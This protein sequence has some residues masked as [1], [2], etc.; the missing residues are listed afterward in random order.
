MS[1]I[2]RLYKEG[3]STYTGWNETP[4]FP[5][6]SAN[7]DTIDDPDGAS[8]RNEITSIPSPFA[9]IDLVKTAF[10]EVC[11]L[12]RKTKK[13][14][15]DGKTIFHKMI[16][17]ALDVG[18]IFF[19]ID[20]YQNKIEIISWDPSIMINALQCDGSDGH[21]YLADALQKYMKSDSKTYNFD[22]LQ[23]IYLLNY[24]DGPDELNIIGATSPATLFFSSANKLDYINDIYFAE[25][26]PFDSEFQPLYKRDFEYVK[27]WFTLR[28][29]IPSFSTLFP[30]L[31]MYLNLTFKAITDTKQKN[32]LN[33]LTAASVDL[34]STI[35]VVSQQQNN[36]VE[37][38]GHV[39]YKKS[40]K[41]ATEKSEFTICL[42]G[43]T[44]SGT[45]PLVLPIEA[46][47]KYSKLQYT[48]GKWGTT[49]VAPYVDDVVELNKRF[50]PF[51]GAQ[52][53]YLTISD[54]LEDTIIRVPHTLNKESFYDGNIVI[55]EAKLSY[56]LP[57]KILFFK[58]FSVL[59]LLTPLSNGKSMLEMQTVAGGSVRVV[60][61][62]PIVGN[63]TVSYIEYSRSYYKERVA[64]I[65][66]NEGGMTEFNFTGLVM[67][68]VKFNNQEDAYYTV[69]C[70]STFSRKFNLEFFSGMDKINSILMACRNE[71][72]LETYKA[73]TYTIEKHNFDYIQVSDRNGFCGVLLP[74]YKNQRN[75]DTFEFAIDLGT[76]NTHI[77]YCKEGEDPK[78]FD[79]DKKDN[80]VCEMFVPSLVE[81]KGEQDDLIEEEQLIEK[82]FLPAEVGEG[83]FVFPTRTILSCSKTIDWT[84][85]IEPYG[86]F[87]IPLTY[88]KRRDLQ[89][90]NIKYNI[91]WGKGDEYRVIESYVNCLMLMIRN[92]VLLNNGNLKHTKI[93]WFYPIS[94]APKRLRKLQQT[95]DASYEKYFGKGTTN[96]MT[97]SAAPIQYFFRRY[98]TATNLVNID[99]G[100]G[101]TDIAFAKNKEIQF[102]TSFKFASN[103]LFE[104]PFSDLDKD[105]GIVDRYKND[106]LQLLKDKK[107]T[108][109]DRIF[110]SPNN[111]NPANL[112]SFLFSLKNNSMAKE[113]D[114]KSI[115]F[116]YI[117][118]EDEDFKIVFILFYTSIIYN[119][120]KIIKEKGLAV[121]RHITFSGN[122]S[123]LIKVVSTDSKLLAKY[124]KLIFEKVTGE[125]YMGDL[126]ILGL[127]KDANPK[128][129]TCKGGI[130]GVKDNDAR[131]KI[132]I[133]KGSSGFVEESDTYD[134]VDNSYIQN[135]IKSVCGFFD[136]ALNTM[137]ADFNFDENFGV[138][139]NSLKIAKCICYKDLSTFLEKGIAQRREEAEGQD[140][141]EETFFF[142]PI[143]GALNALSQAIYESLQSNTENI[144]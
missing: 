140:K 20:K 25:D 3:T 118:Q 94:M 100:G 9:R 130:I 73:E 19:N 49:N 39:L 22:Q 89:Y 99:I 56:L 6:N 67:P 92:K 47:N 142:Y 30:E 114:S 52:S 63:A 13:V 40:N 126:D 138:T 58:Y 33:N 93:T 44:D 66:R 55:G 132:I 84:G 48:T 106:I 144:D 90:N 83:D 64:D 123:K 87:N 104:N 125:K 77:E 53:P 88:D 41:P 76:S 98:A 119:I 27:V 139:L 59:D 117:L 143:K 102:V 5:Y 128:E 42:N 16:S 23:N 43:K 2:F 136:F 15:L 28:K 105:N 12:D 14:E 35:D 4:A 111:L 96:C 8:A 1:K 124:T 10:K 131:S 121:P 137:N 97:E 61:R 78:V 24:I 32:E 70:I 75:V 133:F 38:L 18:E 37:V 80:Q 82:D 85:V 81:G 21:L 110:R 115:D 103:T 45:L 69:S 113:V 7:R 134:H 127:D 50:L 91:K 68:I 72:N 29:A 26:R 31:E 71:D 34:F 135:T 116:N 108:E 54:F 51:D 109:L 141:I 129:A 17:D 120:A 57:L 122:G 101:T 11:K 107:L 74:K 65:Q 36:S 86:L 112:A 95:W 46:G 79:F 62:I 60:L